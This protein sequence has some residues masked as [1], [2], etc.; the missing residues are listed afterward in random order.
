MLVAQQ[1]GARIPWDCSVP[2]A[3]HRPLPQ[4]AGVGA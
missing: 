1:L 2:L 4:L 3:E